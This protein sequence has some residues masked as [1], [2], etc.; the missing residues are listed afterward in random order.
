MQD[1]YNVVFFTVHRVYTLIHFTHDMQLTSYIIPTSYEN[2][3]ILGI[4]KT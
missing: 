2:G 1:Y 4:L 3:A